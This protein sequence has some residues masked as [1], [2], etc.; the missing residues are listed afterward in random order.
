MVEHEFG[1]D[2]TED[3]LRRLKEYLAAYRRIFTINQKASWFTTWYVD[4][5]AG[6]GTRKANE[7]PAATSREE[8]G[9]DPDA[10]AYLDGSARIALGLASPFDRYLF[11]E[12]AL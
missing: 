6:T 4:A 11:V 9:V 7:S 3:K 5:F 10:I 12:T 2:W 1:G 8:Y